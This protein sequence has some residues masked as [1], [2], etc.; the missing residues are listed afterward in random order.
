[1]HFDL[2]KTIYER[3]TN[4]IKKQGIAKDGHKSITAVQKI[5]EI[6]EV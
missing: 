1:M 3:Q 5:S 2:T 4:N 6:L